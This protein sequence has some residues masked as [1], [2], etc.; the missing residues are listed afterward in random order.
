MPVFFLPS[1]L[2]APPVVTITGDLLTHI[3]NSLRVTVGESLFVAGLQGPRYRVEVTAITKESVTARIVET[4]SAPPPPMGKIILGQALLKGDK[5]DW[6]I[7][8]ATELGVDTI[9]PIET[10]H[11]VVQPKP[12]RIEHQR[13]RWQ[14]IALEAAQQSEQWRIASVME[15]VRMAVFLKDRSR[16]SAC[17]MLTERGKSAMS[18]RTVNLPESTD[19]CIALLIGPE[20]GWSA[21]ELAEA[22]QA[23]CIPITLGSHILRAETAAIT[24]VANLQHRLGN[25]G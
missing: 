6:V 2:I 16:F 15:P 18:L 22:E 1:D 17:L 24:A 20:G 25:L 21:D 9:V 3:R 13:A 11:G 4:I 5:M 12:G 8:N 23:G 7:Q 19:Q 10:Q 14:R